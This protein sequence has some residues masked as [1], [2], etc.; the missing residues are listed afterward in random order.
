ML[1]PLPKILIP[2]N[3]CPI[4]F[5]S[6]LFTHN[7]FFHIAI[8]AVETASCPVGI[9]F[10]NLF[11]ICCNIACENLKTQN[12]QVS[13]RVPFVSIPVIMVEVRHYIVTGAL[14]LKF[15]PDK[16]TPKSFGVF[17]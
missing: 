7:L 4:T 13:V 9:I 8:F 14:F 3:L 12:T 6:P 5:V 1:A 11:V 15:R 16:K 10:F 17:Y 2:Y